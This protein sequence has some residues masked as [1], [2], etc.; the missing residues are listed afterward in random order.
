[1]GGIGDLGTVAEPGFTLPVDCQGQEINGTQDRNY[2]YSMDLFHGH[3]SKNVSGRW[4]LRI[5]IVSGRRGVYTTGFRI[6]RLKENY[7]RRSK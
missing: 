6:S 2:Q 3:S 5:V 1:M 4:E 7:L